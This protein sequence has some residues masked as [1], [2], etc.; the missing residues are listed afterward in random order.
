MIFDIYRNSGGKI[1]WH[2]TFKSKRRVY[3]SEFYN[4]VDY[5]CKISRSVFVF[6]FVKKLKQILPTFIALKKNIY[7]SPY[8]YKTHT[9]TLREGLYSTLLATDRNKTSPDPPGGG[10][11]GG[12]GQ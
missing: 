7:I 12:G 9:G 2:Y 1:L 3:K 11:G 10:G 5:S 4:F 8:K 6:F